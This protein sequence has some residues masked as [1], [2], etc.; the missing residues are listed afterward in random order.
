MQSA[1]FGFSRLVTGEFHQITTLQEFSQALFLC[2]GQ[3]I[4]FAQFIQKLL[5]GAFRRVK[6]E[7]FFQVVADGVRN[8]NAEF[9]RLAEQGEGLGELLFGA[10]VRGNDRNR[11]GLPC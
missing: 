7:P 11:R 8:Q 4:G 9:P 10:N 2:A 6:L 3:Q 5:G 1:Q